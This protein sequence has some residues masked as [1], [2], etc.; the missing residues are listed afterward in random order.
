MSFNHPSKWF[1]FG[2][3]P[4]HRTFVPN[5]W[6]GFVIFFAAIAIPAIIVFTG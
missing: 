1:A 4:G 3:L 2:S 6:E 5:T